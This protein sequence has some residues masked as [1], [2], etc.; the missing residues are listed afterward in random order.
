MRIYREALI[1]AQQS[2]DQEAV[3]QILEGLK[4]V[5]RRRNQEKK[6][7]GADN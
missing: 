1:L 6:E 5:K 4:E 7:D 2:G 3:D